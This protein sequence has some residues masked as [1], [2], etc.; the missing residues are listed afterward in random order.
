MQAGRLRHRLVIQQKSAGSPQRTATGA[1]ST[2]WATLATV[3]GSLEVLAGRR[4]EAAQATWGE[5]TGE[6]MIRYRSEI[7]D[8]SVP[9]RISFGGRFYP[10]GKVFD[11]DGRKVML[12]LLWKE[13]SASG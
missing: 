5:A 11:Q 7:L 8:A 2:S 13:G 6:S 1:K 9:L 4:L 12:K 10:V 3:Y